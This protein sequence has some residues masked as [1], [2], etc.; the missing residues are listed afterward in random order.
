METENHAKVEIDQN[1]SFRVQ[2]DDSSQHIF[3]W[4]RRYRFT[5][6]DTWRYFINSRRNS[7]R[8]N[9]LPTHRISIWENEW[10]NLFTDLLSSF[11]YKLYTVSS[12]SLLT[13]RPL[14]LPRVWLSIF[15]NLKCKYYDSTEH[16]YFVTIKCDQ[17]RRSSAQKTHSKMV[18]NKSFSL[19]S[20]CSRCRFLFCSCFPFIESVNVCSLHTDTHYYECCTMAHR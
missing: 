19:V 18:E 13:D 5:L 12:S 16:T 6:W 4:H 1:I 8:L 20:R 15:S 9:T 7:N 3:I 10:M 14:A 2:H 17:P 11:H